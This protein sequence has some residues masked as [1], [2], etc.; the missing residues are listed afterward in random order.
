MNGR[1]YDPEIKA[2]VL[3][4]LLTGQSINAVAKEYKVPA[5]TVKSWKSRELS[6]KVATV[7]TAKQAD[8][9]ELLIKYM[10]QSLET[11]TEQHEVFRD[12]EWL[13]QQSASD[14]AVLHGVLMDKLM[15]LLEAME[16]R[17]ELT[18]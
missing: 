18:D 3:A 1:N 16:Q 8:V 7:A 5:G 17:V 15:R 13:R 14:A 11:L 10:E 6:E 9:G 4:A 2:A 12:G